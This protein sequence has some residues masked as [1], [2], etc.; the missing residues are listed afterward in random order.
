[1]RGIGE[2]GRTKGKWDIGE[3]L[4][5]IYINSLIGTSD[6]AKFLSLHRV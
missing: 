3:R 5:L 6:G 4:R 2:K 1:M